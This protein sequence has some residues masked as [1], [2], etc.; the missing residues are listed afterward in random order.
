MARTFTRRDTLALLGT[1]GLSGCTMLDEE[2]TPSFEDGPAEWSG[3]SPSIPDDAWPMAKRT[4]GATAATPASGPTDFPLEQ[5]WTIS[6]SDNLH[7]PTVRNGTVFLSSTADERNVVAVDATDGTELWHIDS[8]ENCRSAP[9]VAGGTLFASFDPY[10]DDGRTGMA[11]Y[12]VADGNERWHYDIEYPDGTIVITDSEVLTT[13][14]DARVIALDQ[15]SGRLIWEYK[16]GD[17]SYEVAEL[18][19]TDKVYFATGGSETDYPD[20][21]HVYAFDPTAGERVWSFEL[22]TPATGIAVAEETVIATTQVAVVALDAD[23]GSEQWRHELNMVYDQSIAVRDDCVVVST[24][25]SLAAYAIDGGRRRWLNRRVSGV[26]IGD[27]VV[28]AVSDP[29]E[30]PGVGAYDIQTGEELWF[31]QDAPELGA[32]TIAGGRLYTGTQ[33]GRLIAW[34]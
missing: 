18:A 27:D 8:E 13:G 2:Q 15:E 9:T 33:D 29:E 5:V 3:D 17:P 6:V 16:P 7:R 10:D 34:E 4:P 11:A 12:N 23:T 28:Y 19:V 20:V 24:G 30:N 21:G 25:G 32:P 22:T 1:V 14:S 26:A 31:T